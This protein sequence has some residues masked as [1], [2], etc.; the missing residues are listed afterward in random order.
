MALRTEILSWAKG[1]RLETYWHVFFKA[2]KT[3]QSLKKDLM[4]IFLARSAKKH[5]GYVGKGAYMASRPKLPHGLHGIYISRYASLGEEC[6]IYQNVT[7][8]EVNGKAP[9]IGNHVLIGAGAILVGDITIGDH[10]RIGAGAIV[11]QDIPA[12]ATVLPAPAGIRLYTPKD[13][14]SSND[15]EKKDEKNS[16]Y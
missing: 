10:A 14:S 13:A 9:T 16:D 12:W 3:R 5:G 15:Q 1:D 11:R 2:Q 6:W 4:E 8:G 7:I